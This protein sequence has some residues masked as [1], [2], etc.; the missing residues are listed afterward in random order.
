MIEHRMRTSSLPPMPPSAPKI[1]KG[2][3]LD[4][5]SYFRIKISC[6]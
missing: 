2:Q 4:L 3:I 1:S 6:F 5:K